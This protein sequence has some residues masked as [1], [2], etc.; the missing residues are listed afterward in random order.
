MSREHP[1]T[2]LL[3]QR[4]DRELSAAQQAALD[5]HLA[6]C[7]GCRAQL[8]TLRALSAGIDRYSADLSETT[9]G[10]QR[11]ALVAAMEGNTRRADPASRKIVA[12]LA[13]AASVILAVGISFTS[14]QP[15]QS[16]ATVPHA[17]DNNFIALPGAND[18]LSMEGT[19]VMQVDVPRDAVSLS[20]I[21]AA[22]GA[23]SGL[24]KAEVVVGA[25][26]MARAIR[27]LN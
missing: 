23:G 12:A 4:L 5:C 24:V 22:E 21:P 25:D 7:A 15:V 19:V 18:S 11:R 26:G 27:F 17:A 2:D 3:L 1:T 9:P 14:H 16:P 6:E 13:M 8:Q 20:G 10:G